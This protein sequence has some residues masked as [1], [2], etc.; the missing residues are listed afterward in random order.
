LSAALSDASVSSDLWPKAVEN[1]L[2]RAVPA[3][4]SVLK[5]TMLRTVVGAMSDQFCLGLTR[6]G[7]ITG[8]SPL[9]FVR[10]AG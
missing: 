4:V 6:Y 3:V 9:H 1:K 10:G 7:K 5:E 8:I 2:D